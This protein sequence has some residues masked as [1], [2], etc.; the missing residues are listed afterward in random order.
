MHCVCI[1]WNL[2]KS[3]EKG[4]IMEILYLLIP[5]GLILLG[6]ALKLLFWAVNNGQY[7]DLETEGQRILFDDKHPKGGSLANAHPD[8]KITSSNE[9]K[10][11]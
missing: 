8:Q 3:V 1:V 10:Q 2:K 6:L 5:I 4:K 11:K 9:N 7:D